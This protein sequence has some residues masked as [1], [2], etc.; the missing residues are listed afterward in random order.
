MSQPS[1]EERRKFVFVFTGPTVTESGTGYLDL[2]KIIEGIGQITCK[3]RV[4]ESHCVA[5][6]APVQVGGVTPGQSDRKE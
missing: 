1:S 6:D 2:M 5:L 3:W 4:E